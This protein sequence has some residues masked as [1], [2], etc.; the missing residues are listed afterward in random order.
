MCYEQMGNFLQKARLKAR[1][2]NPARPCKMHAADTT[3]QSRSGALTCATSRRQA[4]CRQEA[5]AR[6]PSHQQS[7]PTVLQAQ[8]SRCNWQACMLQM[9]AMLLQLPRSPTHL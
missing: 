3:R 6:V 7:Q 2:I 1:A 9:K 8:H 4:S 5:R